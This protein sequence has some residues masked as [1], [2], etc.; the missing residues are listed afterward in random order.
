MG[1][2]EIQITTMIEDNWNTA[3]NLVI[4]FGNGVRS[5]LRK[6]RL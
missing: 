3:Q 2:C 1:K 5:L 4:Y 6:H